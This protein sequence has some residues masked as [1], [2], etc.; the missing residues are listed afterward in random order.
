MDFNSPSTDLQ[1]LQTLTL[2]G[3]GIWLSV[4]GVTTQIAVYQRHSKNLVVGS[5]FLLFGA[6]LSCIHFMYYD[7]LLTALPVFLLYQGVQRPSWICHVLV[8]ILFLA[9]AITE[10]SFGEPALETFCILGLWIAGVWIWIRSEGQ[11]SSG[12]S[13]SC[14][15]RET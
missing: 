12:L 2:F 8:G 9:P 7:A 14:A 3:W 6:W 15:A 5:A 10:L 4:L 1:N 13:I 11:P